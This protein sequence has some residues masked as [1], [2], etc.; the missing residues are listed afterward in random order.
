[1]GRLTRR[2]VHLQQQ[3]LHLTGRAGPIR[4]RAANLEAWPRSCIST[5]KTSSKGEEQNGKEHISDG[6]LFG[7]RNRFGRRQRLERSGVPGDGHF[8]AVLRQPRHKGFRARE[9]QQGGA[10][11]RDRSGNRSGGWRRIG[12]VYFHATRDYPESRTA[13]DSRTVRG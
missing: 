13:G 11:S 8:G 5:N 7:P 6:Y 10:W 2:N 9:A 12:L 1:M 3:I 4:R